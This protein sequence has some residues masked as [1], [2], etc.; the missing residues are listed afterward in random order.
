MC[1]MIILTIITGAFLGC[2]YYVWPEI[3]AP[4]VEKSQPISKFK[5][6]KRMS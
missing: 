5:V 2:Y 1:N 4:L 6:L 3:V